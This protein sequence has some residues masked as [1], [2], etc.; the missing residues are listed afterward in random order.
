VS[1]IVV[2]FVIAFAYLLA[3]LMDERGL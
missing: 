1:V 3:C 2:A